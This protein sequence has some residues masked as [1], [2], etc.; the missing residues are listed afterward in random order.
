M[1]DPNSSQPPPESDVKSA[2][3]KQESGVVITTLR[4]IVLGVAIGASSFGALVGGVFDDFIPPRAP[5][6][7][8][9]ERV[10]E[11]PRPK[12]SDEIVEIARDVRAALKRALERRTSPEEAAEEI[13]EILQRKV[14]LNQEHIEQIRHIVRELFVKASEVALEE[15]IDAIMEILKNILF[16]VRSPSPA[17]SPTFS[18]TPSINTRSR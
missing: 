6:Q 13:I 1:S 17:T 18:P 4:K 12:I 16:G 9:I 7:T 14:F 11:Q 8:R 5:E 2:P 10:Y 3:P 15:A